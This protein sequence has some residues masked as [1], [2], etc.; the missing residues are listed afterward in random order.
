MAKLA[1]KNAPIVVVGKSHVIY[2]GDKKIAEDDSSYAIMDGLYPINDQAV[3][4][5][6]SG[7]YGS[8]FY[9][10]VQ[11]IS[12]SKNALV[13]F[14]Y[15]N[16]ALFSTHH[17]RP[18][19]SIETATLVSGLGYENGKHKQA[20]YDGTKP[21]VTLTT[22]SANQL[23]GQESCQ[24]SYQMLDTCASQKRKILAITVMKTVLPLGHKNL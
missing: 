11:A 16:Q 20:F 13:K 10:Y 5:Y 6:F 18:S 12:L 2:L 22:V 14:I 8:R 23:V 19:I 24:F 7:P 1:T 15:H 9:V 17:T 21:N 3:L 4:I